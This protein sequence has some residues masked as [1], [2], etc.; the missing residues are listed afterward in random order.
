MLGISGAFGALG[1]LLSSQL[2][3]LFLGRFG[4]VPIFLVL[5]CLHV[6]AAIT[7][8]F[9]IH[10]ADAQ[11]SVAR[12]SLNSFVATRLVA[13]RGSSHPRQIKK[14]DLDDRSLASRSQTILC[15]LAPKLHLFHA[16]SWIAKI[17]IGW[18][19]WDSPNTSR[20]MLLFQQVFQR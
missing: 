8:H 15:H 10:E 7:I 2:I 19:G 11:T 17:Q 12:E 13:D 4:Y 9:L 5:G 20:G 6:I 16:S 18:K 1:G 14:W 3:G